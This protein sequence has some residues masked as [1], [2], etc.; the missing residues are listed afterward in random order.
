MI[1][2]LTTAWVSI[3]CIA[4]ASVMATLLVTENIY[5]KRLRRE[6]R[7]ASGSTYREIDG[8]DA[9]DYILH[10]SVW[11]WRQYRR[12][13]FWRMV[14]GDQFAELR[15]AAL[16]GD[17]RITGQLPNS[18]NPVTI[19]ARYWQLAQFSKLVT[20]TYGL[21]T[22]ADPNPF[23][24][25]FK[26]VRVSESDL[27]EVWPRASIARKLTTVVYVWCKKRWYAVTGKAAR[28]MWH[29]KRRFLK[30]GEKDQNQPPNVGN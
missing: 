9:L 21:Q 29:I 12:L 30:D 7:R 13:N 23:E 20:L 2:W 8:S 15:R 17:V 3:A 26:H 14:D 28:L 24:P 11:G 25:R 19:P 27:Y 22:D 1:P 6:L 16:S 4:A 10:Q 5:G 18:S